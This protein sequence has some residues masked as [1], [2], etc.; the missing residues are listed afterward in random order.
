MAYAMDAIR[1]S[2]PL[3]WDRYPHRLPK[4]K[5]KKQMKHIK[6]IKHLIEERYYGDLIGWLLIYS[7]PLWILWIL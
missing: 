1:S 6:W 7:I 4:K 5:K 2:K 3:M